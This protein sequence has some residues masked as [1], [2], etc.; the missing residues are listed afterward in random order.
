MRNSPKVE[1]VEV[2][3]QVIGFALEADFTAEHEWGVDQM[4]REFNIPTMKL[5]EHIEKKNSNILNRLFY[6][7]PLNIEHSHNAEDPHLYIIKNKEYLFLTMS[8]NYDGKKRTPKDLN[9]YYYMR[10]DREFGGAW[11]ESEFMIVAKNTKEN[12]EF[13]KM[14]VKAELENDLF[15][16][17]YPDVLKQGLL[18]LKYSGILE[19]DLL[20]YEESSKEAAVMLQLVHDSKIEKTIK[21]NGKGFHAL[22][23]MIVSE[24][25]FKTAHNSYESG[26]LM[27]FLNPQEQRKYASGWYSLAEI[28]EWAEKDS[29]PVIERKKKEDE[30]RIAREKKAN[31]NA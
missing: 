12:L 25:G 17:F 3:G 9:R 5:K 4:K 27:F 15:I 7:I 16:G 14:L 23:P 24:E 1:T 6:K 20:A 22:R 13:F 31:K 10:K 2:N 8:N 28:Q 19:E 26:T 21:A 11:D 18:I 30:E 29:G